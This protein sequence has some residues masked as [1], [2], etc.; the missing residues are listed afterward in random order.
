MMDVS[1]PLMLKVKV[2]RLW[3]LTTAAM[4]KTVAAESMVAIVCPSE[5]NEGARE[6]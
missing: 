2:V 5:W 4:A 1:S 6:E 3:A